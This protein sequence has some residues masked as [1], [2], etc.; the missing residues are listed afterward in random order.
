MYTPP[1]Y[2]TLREYIFDRVQ[3]EEEELEGFPYPCR[4]GKIRNI[5]DLREPTEE[6]KKA[7]DFY[8]MTEVAGIQAALEQVGEAKLNPA[9]VKRYYKARCDYDW[10]TENLER[11][12]RN[13][14]GA[15]AHPFPH[16]YRQALVDS[17][18]DRL[19]GGYNPQTSGPQ[20]M[21]RPQAQPEQ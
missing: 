9:E 16:L 12:V 10:Y 13:Y 18:R 17:T 6:E 1:K 4:D 20:S 14:R 21:P 19:V 15:I 7:V 3:S 8:V 5:W 2:N 11:K